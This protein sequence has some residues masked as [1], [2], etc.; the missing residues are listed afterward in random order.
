MPDVPGSCSAGSRPGS[1]APALRGA[2]AFT[3]LRGR[4]VTTLLLVYLCGLLTGLALPWVVRLAQKAAE[5]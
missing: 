2:F 5:R 4:P 3:A 1:A